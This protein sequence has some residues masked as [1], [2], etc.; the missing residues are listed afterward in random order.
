MKK[1]IY[2]LLVII[3]F[4]S[5]VFSQLT[6]TNGHHTLEITGAV[7]MYYNQR[8]LKP[9]EENQ[10]K[11][12]YKLRDAQ[13]Q[14]EGRVGRTVEYELQVDFADLAS[15]VRDPE[16]PGIMDAYVTYKG[17]DVI[18]V[19]FGYGKTPYSRA[20]RVPFIYTPYWQRAE[21]LRGDIF[22]RRDVGV[23]LSK[24]LWKQRISVFAGS[25]TGLGEISLNGDNDQSG[26][27][28]HMGRAEFAYP[29]RYR[30]RDID[31]RHTPIPMFVIGGNAR[32]T[33]RNLPTGTLF[34]GGAVGEYGLKVIDG[35]RYTWG[36]DASAQ[37]KGFSAQ[38]ELHQ[39]VAKPNS[40][41]SNLF[42]GYT[43]AETGGYVKMGGYVAQVNY[44]SKKLKTIFSSRYEEYNLNDLAP[45]INKRINAALAYQIDGFNSMIKLQYFHILEEE[46]IDPLRWNY[47]IRIG[48]QYLFK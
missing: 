32:Y 36:F 24:S 12:R 37:Y 18:D 45:G 46:S 41:Q 15:S 23:T 21:F 35:E 19:T 27:L 42:Q 34:P 13:I 26:Q 11:D 1:Q 31:T 6:I 17:L 39:L 38:F 5:S 43:L 20:S 29:S 30:Y 28:E 48:W 7:S 47:Q 16:N 3:V 25:Y 9:G 4:S 2:I 40:A 33:K 8:F 10:R 22:A 14:L 44:Y